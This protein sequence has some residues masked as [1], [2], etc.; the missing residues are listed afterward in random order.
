MLDHKN[1]ISFPF[2][3]DFAI[4]SDMATETGTAKYPRSKSFTINF[5]LNI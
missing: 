3:L 2:L 1:E 5:P 4:K